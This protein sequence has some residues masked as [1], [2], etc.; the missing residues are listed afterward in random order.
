MT[1]SPGALIAGGDETQ[2][3]VSE[4]DMFHDC[5]NGATSNNGRASH[6]MGG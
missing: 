3:F 5:A 1:R 4:E 2:E 6:L